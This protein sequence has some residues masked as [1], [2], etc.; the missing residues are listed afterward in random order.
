MYISED[1]D[2]DPLENRHDSDWVASLEAALALL[3][4]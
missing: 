4:K 1:R 3:D 2:D